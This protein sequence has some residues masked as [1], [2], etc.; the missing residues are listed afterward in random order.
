MPCL[1]LHVEKAVAACV[2]V[3]MQ[4]LLPLAGGGFLPMPPPAC[5][6]EVH[7]K[8]A[9]PN[10]Q[11]G[12]GSGGGST[13][14]FLEGMRACCSSVQEPCPPAPGL[15]CRW[16]LLLL[17]QQLQTAVQSGNIYLS[18]KR[19]SHGRPDG[20]GSGCRSCKK[21]DIGAAGNVTQRA[22]V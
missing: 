11:G 7:G 22:Q 5:L 9:D 18:R 2:R 15:R 20:G 3:C 1:A 17:L 16:L 19:P 12:E 8:K 10:G 14:F 13:Y 4:G 21:A 6:R